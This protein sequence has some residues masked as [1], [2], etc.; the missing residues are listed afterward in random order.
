[1]SSF[2]R[3]RLCRMVLVLALGTLL[4]GCQQA[5]KDAFERYVPPAESMRTQLTHVLDGW[6]KGLSPAASGNKQGPE[7]HVVDQTRRADQKLARYEILGEAPVDNARAFDVRVTY[8]GVD[9]PEI[10]RFIAIGVDPMWIFRR[11]DYEGIWQHNEDMSPSDRAGE[12]AKK[13]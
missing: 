7:V 2:H 10:V 9:E 1:M 13:P 12:P 8:V 11:E 6:V 4:T 3:G 5:S